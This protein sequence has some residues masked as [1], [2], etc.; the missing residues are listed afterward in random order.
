[1][2]TDETA[3]LADGMVGEGIEGCHAVDCA[4]KRSFSVL[5]SQPSYGEPEWDSHARSATTITNKAVRHL[6]LFSMTLLQARNR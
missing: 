3:R 6:S 4:W 1:M 2:D 5:P